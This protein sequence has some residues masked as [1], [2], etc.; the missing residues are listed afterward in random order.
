MARILFTG[1]GGAGSEALY[2]HLG[3]KHDLYFADADIDSINPLIPANRRIQIPWAQNPDFCDI[4]LN[5]CV[6]NA[7]DYLVPGVDEELVQ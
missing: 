5:H 3:N 7:V 2:R 1:G 6:N 4:L